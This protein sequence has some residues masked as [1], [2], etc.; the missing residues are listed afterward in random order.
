M[1]KTRH[2]YK[3]ISVLTVG[4]KVLINCITIS[5][6]SKVFLLLF[7]VSVWIFF[8]RAQALKISPSWFLQLFCQ[9]MLINKLEELKI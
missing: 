9:Y 2:T 6:G 8:K 5:T 1:L 7:T 4:G 3:K